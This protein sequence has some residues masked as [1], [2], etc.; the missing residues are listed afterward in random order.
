MANIVERLS[1]TATK[2]ESDIPLS[3]NAKT[4]VLDSAARRFGETARTLPA[5]EFYLLCDQALVNA[6]SLGDRDVFVYR[7][8]FY[9]GNSVA[10]AFLSISLGLRLIGSP[11]CVLIGARVIAFHRAAITLA[12]ALTAFGAWLAYRRYLRFREYKFKTCFIRFLSLSED[13][14]KAAPAKEET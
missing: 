9:R 7:E 5:K 3:Q 14:K 1:K 11:A 13:P 12:A 10:L 2:L 4:M 8:G 6:A